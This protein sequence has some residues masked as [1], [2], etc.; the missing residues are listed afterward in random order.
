MKLRATL[1]S[2]VRA[3]FERE[4]VLEVDTPALS[5]AA[6][7][8]PHLASFASRYYGPGVR[9]GARL[10]LHTSPEFPMKRLL[11]A[12]SESIYQICKVFRD[13]EDDALQPRIHAAG[14]VPDPLR[15]PRPDERG[16]EAANRDPR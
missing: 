13:G 4:G 1:L 15:P 6:T 8:S 2:R 9:Q 12:G 14:M 7:T 3:R 11:A 16:R 5:C 10:Y